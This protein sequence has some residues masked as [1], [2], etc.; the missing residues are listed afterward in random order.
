MKS[1]RKIIVRLGAGYLPRSLHRVM[2]SLASVGNPFG[3][4]PEKRGAWARD[5]G[6]KP[7]TR[8]MELLLFWAATLVMTLASERQRRR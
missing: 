6:V 1:L 3:E 4:A 7:F 8:D 2:A 5:L